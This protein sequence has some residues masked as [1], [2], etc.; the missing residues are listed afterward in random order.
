M[1][2]VGLFFFFIFILFVLSS[3]EPVTV[4]SNSQGFEIAASSVESAGRNVLKAALPSTASD[5]VSVALGEGIAG[6]LGALAT[7]VLSFPLQRFRA[8]PAAAAAAAGPT[9]V[10]Q[11]LADGDYFV[12]RAAALPLLEALGLSPLAASVSSVILASVPYEVIKQLDGSRRVAFQRTENALM[13]EL[14]QEELRKQR[15]RPSLFRKLQQGQ[16]EIISVDPKSLIPA[17]Q[18]ISEAPPPLDVVELFTD[19]TKWLEYDVLKSDLSGRLLWN[20]QVLASNVDSALF[21][22][23]A[24]LS[25][26]LYADVAYTFTEYGTEEKRREARQRSL[27]G[28]I[29][30]YVRISLNSAVLFGVY[31]SVKTPVSTAIAGFL[32]R[33]V[34][35]CVGSDDYNTCMDAYMKMNPPEADAAAQLRSLLTAFVSL[36]DRLSND[37]S[38]D[39][40]EFTR[41]VVV[42]L[43][44]LAQHIFSFSLFT[45]NDVVNVQAGEF[46]SL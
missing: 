12:T 41:S 10:R 23:V 13:E 46:I 9:V 22:F 34:E 36:S 31:E 16:Q 5:V 21:G 25:S 35:N 17:I 3:N 44:S 32:S 20:G 33:G 38:M 7:L 2:T 27:A 43:Y 1:S 18:T 14:L 8:S 11:A 6:V 26:Q 24:A 42:Q 30:L 37:G 39:R 40:A 19:I 4:S 29:Q 28:W 45:S 15:Q